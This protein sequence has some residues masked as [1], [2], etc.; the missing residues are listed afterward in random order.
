[1]R[2]RLRQISYT[3]NQSDHALPGSAY[4]AKVDDS[5]VS[6]A[7]N[8]VSLVSSFR[9]LTSPAKASVQNGTAA[10]GKDENVF[11]EL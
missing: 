5:P 6:F 3:S 9:L 11:A 1:M 10:G 7:S 4:L 8:V 2:L